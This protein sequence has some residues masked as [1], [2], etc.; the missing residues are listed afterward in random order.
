M[1]SSTISDN[2]NTNLQLECFSQ[3]GIGHNPLPNNNKNLD[4]TWTSY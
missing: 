4:I 3:R 2:N 1:N